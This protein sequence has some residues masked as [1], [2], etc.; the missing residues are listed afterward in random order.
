MQAVSKLHASKAQINS[1]VM[2]M[3]QQLATMRMAGSLQHSTEVMKN[4]Q[5]LVKVCVSCFLTWEVMHL[6]STLLLRILQFVSGVVVR[7]PLSHDLRIPN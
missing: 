4:M 3:Q 7:I 5:Q 1:V 6:R 2:C